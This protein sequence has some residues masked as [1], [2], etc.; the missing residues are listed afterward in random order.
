MPA[1]SP[2]A[3]ATFLALQD[4]AS[5]RAKGTNT[6]GVDTFRIAMTWARTFGAHA[7][8]PALDAAQVRWFFHCVTGLGS[9]LTGL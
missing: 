3:A 5:C 1:L 8:D 2:A 7:A 9:S 6:H 4:D